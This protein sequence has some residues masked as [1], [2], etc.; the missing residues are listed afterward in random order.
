M[1]LMNADVYARGMRSPA[2]LTVLFGLTLP[3]LAELPVPKEC[4]QVVCVTAT[5]WNANAGTLQRWERSGGDASWTKVGGVVDVV[6]GKNGMGWGLGL[7]RVPEGADGPR[8]KEGDGRSPAGMF[9]LT[10]AFG[11]GAAAVG[12]LPWVA[13]A[14]TTEAVDDPGSRYYNRIVDRGRVERVDWK[15]SEKM[16]E[17]PVYALGVVVAHNPENAPGEGSCIFV[18]LQGRSRTGT[19]GCTALR[20]GD[21]RELVGWLDPKRGPVMIQLPEAVG[22]TEAKEFLGK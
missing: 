1:A 20:E 8:K 14:R 9:R 19:A 4:G 17:I 13:I 3:C 11:F 15:S 2:L 21:L 16:A 6:I 22:R 12:R 18:H 7:H 10:G 5:G